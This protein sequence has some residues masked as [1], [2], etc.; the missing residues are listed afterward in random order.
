[1]FHQHRGWV[2]RAAFAL[3][4][5]L[6]PVMASAHVYHS[7]PYHYSIRV[8]YR[9]AIHRRRFVRHHRA[10][11]HIR[12]RHRDTETYHP[13]P[14]GVVRLYQWRANWPPPSLAHLVAVARSYVG[15][16]KFTGIPG[17]WC[18]DAVNV[19]LR[20]SGF[21][22]GHSRRAADVDRI[23]RRMPGPCVGCIARAR[24]G[25]HTGIVAGLGGRGWVD[26]ISGN[27]A[28]RVHE[29][30]YS[31]AGMSFYMPEPRG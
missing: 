20:L 21:F 31:T 30:P 27:W 13:H 6:T 1:M 17:P 4:V 3:S 22:T 10:G 11:P 14:R 19:W 15:R 8:H 28:G 9:H 29:G 7:K 2:L 26:L 5:L 18:R 16:G 12:G 23:G 25:H 24:W